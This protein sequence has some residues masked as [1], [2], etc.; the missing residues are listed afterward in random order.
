M[1]SPSLSRYQVFARL[2]LERAK[3]LM[4][5]VLEKWPEDSIGPIVLESGLRCFG[6]TVMV[7]QGGSLWLCGEGEVCG[8]GEW[9]YCLFWLWLG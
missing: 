3:G 5:L 1:L 6:L 7:I 8:L 2:Q 4:L 9:L